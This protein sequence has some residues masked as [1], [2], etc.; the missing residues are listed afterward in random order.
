ML[1]H[2][3][4]FLLQLLLKINAYIFLMILLQQKFALV[5]SF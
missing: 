2:E 1:V 3:C 5:M 4:N